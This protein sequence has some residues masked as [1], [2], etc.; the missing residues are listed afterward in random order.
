MYMDVSTIDKTNLL[1][2][3]LEKL[4]IFLLSLVLK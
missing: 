4:M 2:I 3:A 1:T